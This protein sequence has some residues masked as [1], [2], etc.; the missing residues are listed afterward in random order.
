MCGWLL[1]AEHEAVGGI[2][3]LEGIHLCLSP[4]GDG[5]ALFVAEVGFGV[6]AQPRIRWQR[7]F[8]FF[9]RLDDFL[10]FM[11]LHGEATGGEGGEVEFATAFVDVVRQPPVDGLEF[12]V[13]RVGSFVAVAVVAGA[14]EDYLHIFGHVVG[15]GDV[16][17]RV[18]G[19]GFIGMKELD[20][21]ED[22]E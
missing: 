4:G 15:G 22:G 3:I 16:V 12:G 8:F 17:A 13:P 6:E 14:V 21:D 19:H 7:H 11:V 20:D 2:L 9:H 10:E 5:G 1:A 18:V